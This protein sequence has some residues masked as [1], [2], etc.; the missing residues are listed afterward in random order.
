MPLALFFFDTSLYVHVFV[1]HYPSAQPPHVILP[2]GLNLHVF[3]FIHSSSLLL[4]ECSF[5]LL[6]IHQFT[7]QNDDGLAGGS[8]FGYGE[9]V[10]FANDWRVQDGNFSLS[11]DGDKLFLYCEAATGDPHHLMALSYDGPYQVPGRQFYGVGESALP[12]E[13]RDLGTILLPPNFNNYVYEGPTEADDAVLKAAIVNPDSWTG[14]NDGRFRLGEAGDAAVSRH[15]MTL[16]WVG[17]ATVV[18]II[19]ILFCC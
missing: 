11:T 18:P 14:R 12:Q 8:V 19:S 3:I 2:H 15:G 16:L 9:G 10:P 7:V 6:Y 17:L 1:I 5:I 4:F 13:L